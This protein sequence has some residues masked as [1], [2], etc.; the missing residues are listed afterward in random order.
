[1]PL[2]LQVGAMKLLVVA[3]AIIAAL[4]IWLAGRTDD[5]RDLDLWSVGWG[6]TP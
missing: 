4:A 5:E 1:M 2:L 3:F 6:P